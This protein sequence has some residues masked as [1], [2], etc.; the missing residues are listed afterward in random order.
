MK[1]VKSAVRSSYVFAIIV[2]SV[3]GTGN[4]M[5]DES[6]LTMREL[7]SWLEAYGEAWESRDADA[8]AEIFSDDATYRV[9][10]YEEPH[11][12]KDGVRNYWA[13]VTENQRNIQFEHRAI[14][15]TGNTG[16]AHWLAAFEVEPD[17]T[18]I[19]LDGIFV[20]EFD[21]DGK[22]RQL[23]EWWHLKTGAAAG[24]D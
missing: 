24:Q 9:T 4:T 3:F 12:G 19:E 1:T 6:T 8:A 2:A 21:E 23:R 22:C 11:I 16:V 10:P 20:L 15:V 14:S 13:G 7:S 5:A 18:K 17:G